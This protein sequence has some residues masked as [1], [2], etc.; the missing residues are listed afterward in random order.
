[1][2]DLAIIVGWILGTLTD[3]IC[4]LFFW[5]GLCLL[6]KWSKTKRLGWAFVFAIA[7]HTATLPLFRHLDSIL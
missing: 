1:M 5:I 3:P 4:W 2:H 6:K 7:L